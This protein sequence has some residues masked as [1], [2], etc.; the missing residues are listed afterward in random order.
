MSRKPPKSSTVGRLLSFSLRSFSAF[1]GWKKESN[2]GSCMRVDPK[3]KTWIDATLNFVY[4]AVC[5]ICESE[6]VKPEE[7]YVCSSCWSGKGGVRFITAPFCER[8]GLP[9]EGEITTQFKCGNCHEM[10]LHFRFARSSV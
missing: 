1:A 9:F 5:Q 3:I 6:R 4:P 2:P 10:D 7:G 8:C